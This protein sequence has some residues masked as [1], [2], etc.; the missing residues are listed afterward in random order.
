MLQVVEVGASAFAVLNHLSL[1]QAPCSL[2]QYI[3]GTVHGVVH[4]MVQHT[5][6]RLL[7][8]PLPSYQALEQQGRPAEKRRPH[9]GSQ[10][11]EA[12]SSGDAEADGLV[13]LLSARPGGGG[14][15][16]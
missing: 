3:R 10:R 8:S 14:G 9:K 16:C 7:P 13:K 5:T 11:K 6:H 12:A 15:L 1:Q 4:C 2:L